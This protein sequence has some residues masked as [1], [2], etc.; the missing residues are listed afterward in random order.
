M[1][2]K[3]NTTGLEPLLATQQNQLNII[4]SA[5]S[6]IDNKALAILAADI[7]ALA[8]IG[9]AS[10]AFQSW[11]QH[12]ALLGPYILSLVFVALTVQPK[13]YLGASIDLTKHPEY[14]SLG[15][16]AL[17]LQLL[18]DTQKAITH[19]QTINNLHWRQCLIAAGFTIIGTVILFA[20]L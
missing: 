19:N 9:Q 16:E 18:A 5:G 15:D 3:Q 12:T 17:L 8:F 1:P 11:L 13:K 7:A 6:S 4:M 14:L 10:I 20:I 2:A